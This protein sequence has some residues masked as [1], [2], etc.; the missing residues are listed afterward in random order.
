[1]KPGRLS[2][3]VTGLFVLALLA[4]FYVGKVFLLPLALALLLSFVFRPLTRLL[5][6]CHV[7]C[8]ASALF[9]VAMI[10]AGLALGI[11][12]LSQPAQRWLEEAPGSL[13]QLEYRLNEWT[14][15]VAEAREATKKIAESMAAR[16]MSS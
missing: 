7:S 1:M 3:P 12:S 14:Q 10:G 6:R 11:Y 8:P 16:G 13:R 15:P 9:I 4:T 5:S 2:I